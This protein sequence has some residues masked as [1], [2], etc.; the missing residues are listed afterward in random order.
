MG[1]VQ[2][3]GRL[4]GR[5]ITKVLAKAGEVVAVA[6]VIA[7]ANRLGSFEP[8]FATSPINPYVIFC[9]FS[10]VWF[11]PWY[12][13]LAFA[14]SVASLL[15]PFPRGGGPASLASAFLQ[16]RV[17]LLWTLVAVYVFGLVHDRFRDQ[18]DA[19]SRFLR[20]S[21]SGKARLDT[22]VK[23]LVEVNRDLEERVLRQQESITS[24]FARI[25][26]M[27]TQSVAETLAVLL[28]MVC[29]YSWASKAS[30]WRFRPEDDCLE[31]A[32]TIGWE[33]DEKNPA[34]IPA[35]ESV[36][37]WVARNNLV[38]SARML[39]SYANL[40]RMD[41]GRN[42]LTFPISFGKT[43]WG[44]LNIEDMPFSKF[45]L[46]TEK[47]LG[48]LIEL[49]SPAIERTVADERLLLAELHPLTSFPLASVLRRKMDLWADSPE[50]RKSSFSVIILELASMKTLTESFGEEK[51]YALLRRCMG[52]IKTLSGNVLEPY[53]YENE[54]QIA[55]FY[56]QIDFDGT[57]LFCFDLLGMLNGKTWEIDEKI[58]PM[59]VFLGYANSGKG[60]IESDAILRV[61]EEVL[62][63]QKRRP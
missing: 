43:V 20:R 12:G 61:A 9:L 13:L 32:A 15:V 42:L 57:A 63:K 11:G 26:E 46:Y 23:A 28:D 3:S 59:D 48:V 49:G 17:P 39:V 29:Q 5:P 45:N 27:T 2:A 36:E 1:K 51:A 6:A 56:P 54:G 41:K 37:G 40:R 58:V 19:K 8:G 50:S 35:A 18:L 47:I 60:K 25:R 44:V 21:A 24:L 38:F 10:A 33:E 14:A 16:Y 22:E 34:R 31:C 4:L 62:E 53:H 30:V 52:E 7:A 55:L